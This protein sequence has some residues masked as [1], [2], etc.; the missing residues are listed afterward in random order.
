MPRY[1]SFFLIFILFYFLF[2]FYVMFC[3][4]LTSPPLMLCV[5]LQTFESALFWKKKVEGLETESLNHDVI[6]LILFSYNV[7]NKIVLCM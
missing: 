5:Y 1:L 7:K 3:F 4:F 6:I 2:L